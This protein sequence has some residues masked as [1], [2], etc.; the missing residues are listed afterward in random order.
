MLAKPRLEVRSICL[1]SLLVCRRFG[2][3]HQT[4]SPLGSIF[5]PLSAR[6]GLRVDI[7]KFIQLVKRPGYSVNATT[8]KKLVTTSAANGY[9]MHPMFVIRHTAGVPVEDI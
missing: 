6:V 9:I 7:V 8:R 1:P 4:S 2:Y 5:L 3:T